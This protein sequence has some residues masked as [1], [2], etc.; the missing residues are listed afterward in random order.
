MWRF[1]RSSG[2]GGQHVNTS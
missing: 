2:P 1:S